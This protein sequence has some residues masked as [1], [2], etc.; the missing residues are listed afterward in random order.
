MR[1]LDHPGWLSRVQRQG[2]GPAG[3]ALARAWSP[4]RAAPG[5]PWTVEDGSMSTMTCLHRA[6]AA[7][8]RRASRA[9]GP[10]LQGVT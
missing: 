6:P 4:V 8:P 10:S 9:C 5:C 3:G 7:L 2:P 1:G